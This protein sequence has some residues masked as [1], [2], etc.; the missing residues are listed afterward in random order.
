MRITNRLMNDNA[1]YYMEENLQKLY[2]LQEKVSSGKQFQR[3][4]DNPVQATA[5]LSLRSTMKISQGYLDT[6][7]SMN[8]WMSTTDYSMQQ[9][10]KSAKR[11]LNLAQEGQSDTIGPDER[12]ALAAEMDMILQQAV[13]IGNTS[14][15]GNYIY[16]GFK[17]N[18][19]PF[20]LLDNN[21]DGAYDAVNYNG[22]SGVILRNVGPGQSI[23]QNVDG[24]A[25]FSPLF[26]A[27]IQARDAL[28]NNDK[29]TLQTAVGALN[30]ALDGINETTTTNG[31]RQRQ[32]TQ[33]GERLE[34]T[35]IELKSLLSQKEDVNMT[36]AVSSLRYQET[37]YQTVLEVGNR[38]ISTLNL[39]DK[40]G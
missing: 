37:V 28:G 2:D 23:P 20:T 31:A 15:Q 16:S 8:A 30:T 10:V 18:T 6:T 4:S 14:H 25:S 36:E 17:T 13:G 34:K 39:F 26:S 3:A 7:R 40:I 19:V 24:N 38:A 21:N 32:V 12:K 22:D 33:I 35:Q 29:A 9:M 11:A 5:A 27:L 1:V